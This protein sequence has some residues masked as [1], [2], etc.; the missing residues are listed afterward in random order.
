[1]NP[2]LIALDGDG[3]LLD[4]AAAYGMAWERAFDTKLTV[5][6]PCA[7]WSRARWGIPKLES[8]EL[9]YF[10]TFF[11]EEF[12]ATVPVLA[13]AVE[14]CQDLVHAGYSLVCVS[15]LPTEFEH[16]RRDNLRSHGIA[17]NRVYATPAQGLERNPKATLIHMLHPI[18]FVDDYLPYMRE[19]P[20]TVHKALITREPKGSP[21]DAPEGATWVNSRHTTLADFT[22]WWLEAGTANPDAA[23][24]CGKEASHG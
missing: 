7:Y 20:E 15:A 17:V 22:R 14:A 3:V 23:V 9:A 13:G 12:W 6:D 11:D 19:L 24:E 5:V 18:V 2:N 1:M 16:A 8:D 10:Q 4:Y 21:N